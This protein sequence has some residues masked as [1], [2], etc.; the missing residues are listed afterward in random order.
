MISI[1]L[2]NIWKPYFHPVEKVQ[3]WERFGERGT[4]SRCGAVGKYFQFRF[5]CRGSN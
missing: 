2:Y 5:L 3:Q 1:A 4:S